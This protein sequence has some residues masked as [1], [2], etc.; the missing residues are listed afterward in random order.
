MYDED[1]DLGWR[2]RLARWTALYVPASSVRHIWHGSTQRHGEQWLV[3][4]LNTNRVRVLVKNASLGL[5]VRTARRTAS[6]VVELWRLGGLRALGALVR[7]A[8]ES[9]MA[10]REVGRLAKRRRAEL[11]RA[12]VDA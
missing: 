4:R 7:A 1:F 10:R 9:L 3:Q 11:E 8:V 6:D 2:A 5:I 12:W